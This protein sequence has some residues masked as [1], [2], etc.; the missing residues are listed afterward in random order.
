MKWP[1]ITCK[2]VAVTRP[3]VFAGPFCAPT[4]LNAHHQNSYQGIDFT[5][6]SLGHTWAHYLILE[7]WTCTA[8]NNQRH[9]ASKVEH[10]MHMTSQVSVAQRSMRIVMNHPRPAITRTTLRV[11]A[12]CNKADCSSKQLHVARR[13]LLLA[14]PVLPVLLSDQFKAHAEGA[15]AGYRTFLGMPGLN[16]PFWTLLMKF[17]LRRPFQI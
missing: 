14:G 15:S 13:S 12:A 6:K 5:T 9:T 1:C 8:H 11:M 2:A 7:S 17:M 4:R 3:L 16:H 10:P